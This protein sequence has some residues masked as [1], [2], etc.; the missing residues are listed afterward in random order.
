MYKIERLLINLFIQCFVHTYD[1]KSL[2]DA[3]V[4]VPRGK[5]IALNAYIREKSLKLNCLNFYLKKLTKR[6]KTEQSKH[7]ES[8]IME[9]RQKQDD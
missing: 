1:Q 5:S 7:K 3:V 2:L 6:K 8:R 9:I 4:A